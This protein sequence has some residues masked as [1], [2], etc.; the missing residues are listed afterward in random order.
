MN[1]II[2]NE[3]KEEVN[4]EKYLEKVIREVLKL[5]DIDEKKCEISLSF[6]D[7]EKIRQLN[8]D[9]RSIDRVTDV[10]SFPIEDFLMKIGKIYWKNP[11][12]CL[13][14]L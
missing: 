3:T 12:L 7:E 14:M 2:N 8:K 10:L 1:L 13:E 9:F 5:E 6:V 11:I 4:I